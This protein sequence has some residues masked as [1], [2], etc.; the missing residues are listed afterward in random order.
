MTPLLRPIALMLLAA[1]SLAA[2][3]EAGANLS[4]EIDPQA[5]AGLWFEVAR[6]PTPFQQQ[7]AGGVTA[8]YELADEDTVR[9]LNRCDLA[10]GGTE[11]IEGSAEVADGNF[12]TFSVTFPQSPEAPGVN[13]VV[14]AVGEPEDGR[15][16]WAAVH[17]PEAG[18]GWILSRDPDLDAAARQEAEDALAAAGL[19]PAALQDTPQPPETYDPAS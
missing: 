15:Y 17:S 11:G 8:S 3:Q 2:A 1:P 14:A 6:I 10:D 7:C 18:L 13:Y 12:N 9:V 4:T 19:D 16:H 5:Y